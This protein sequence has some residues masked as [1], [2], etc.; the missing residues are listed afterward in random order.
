MARIIFS[1]T[2]R[3]SLEQLPRDRILLAAVQHYLQAA[4]DNPEQFTEPAPFPHRPDRLLC[5]FR[6]L[7]SAR[8][9][10]AFSVLFARFEDTMRVTY[11]AFN[12]AVGEPYEEDE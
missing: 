5:T 1:H 2:A 3:V 8:T 10:Y 9:E 7:D 12:S 6:T 4:A 11:F